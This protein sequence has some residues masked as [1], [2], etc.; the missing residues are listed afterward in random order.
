MDVQVY[1]GQCTEVLCFAWQANFPGWVG[2]ILARGPHPK[3]NRFRIVFTCK[4][5]IFI[6]EFI[7]CSFVIQLANSQITY[8]KNNIH[9]C[10][11]LYIKQMNSKCEK[12]ATK[13]SHY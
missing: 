10:T 7:K 12:S 5:C 8:R 9:L 6:K 2:K 11:T 4:M 13:F 3:C 1:R